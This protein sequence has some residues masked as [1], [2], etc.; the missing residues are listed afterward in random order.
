MS[1]HGVAVVWVNERKGRGLSVCLGASEL[2]KHHVQ[3]CTSDTQN[4]RFSVTSTKNS[5]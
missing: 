5:D 3:V 4:G 2:C 1:L